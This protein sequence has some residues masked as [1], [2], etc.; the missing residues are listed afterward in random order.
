VVIRAVKVFVGRR[1]RELPRD[2]PGVDAVEAMLENG[3]RVPIGT[4]TDGDG[5][6]KGLLESG[7]IV[8]AGEMEDAEAGALA[9]RLCGE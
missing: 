1:E 9:P 2:P 3:V 6:A 7:R 5:P 4:G 8:A